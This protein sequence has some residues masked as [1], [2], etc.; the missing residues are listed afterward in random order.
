MCRRSGFDQ[1]QSQSAGAILLAFARRFCSERAVMGHFGLAETGP[2]W[3]FRNSH[4]PMNGGTRGGTA[5]EF[6]RCWKLGYK[7]APLNK[8]PAGLSL[9]IERRT[10]GFSLTRCTAEEVSG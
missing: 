4:A 2:I 9:D 1:Q 7:P 3:F 8:S 6:D 10:S 5:S